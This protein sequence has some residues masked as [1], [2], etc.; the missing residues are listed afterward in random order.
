MAQVG[1]VDVGTVLAA[2]EAQADLGLLL[3]AA[4]LLGVDRVGADLLQ[5]RCAALNGKL[6]SGLGQIFKAVADLAPDLA[7]AA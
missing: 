5:V 2:V 6:G 4:Q 3:L 7:M 1:E